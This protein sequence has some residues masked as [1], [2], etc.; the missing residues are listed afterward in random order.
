MKCLSCNSKVTPVEKE[1]KKKKLEKCVMCSPPEMLERCR[2]S[3]VFKPWPCCTSEAAGSQ[4]HFPSPHISP[5][6]DLTLGSVLLPALAL[7]CADLSSSFYSVCQLDEGAGSS[8][9]FLSQKLMEMGTAENLK[10]RTND[11]YFLKRQGGLQF[12]IEIIS[13][14]Q[15]KWQKYDM[16]IGKWNFH[17][18]TEVSISCFHRDA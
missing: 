13:F 12:N 9:F 2:Q 6:S 1:K 5:Q 7:D 18:M 14:A 8:F 4:H 10:L 17:G 15:R 3:E 11:I 16:L